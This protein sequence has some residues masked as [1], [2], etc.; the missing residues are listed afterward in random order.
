MDNGKVEVWT[1]TNNRGRGIFVT[2][3]IKK[4]EVIFANT[5]TLDVETLK[6]LSTDPFHEITKLTIA[7]QD[8]LALEVDHFVQCLLGKA[9]VAI[10]AQEATQALVLVEKIVQR[11]TA[12]ST[13]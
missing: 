2:K 1:T 3:E 7:K 12:T 5:A 4:D 6:V 9:T 13:P 11:L 8:A 10:T